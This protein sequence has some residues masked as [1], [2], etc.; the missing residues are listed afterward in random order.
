MHWL[1]ARS[2]ASEML[3]LKGT[4]NAAVLDVARA[5]KGGL[6]RACMPSIC[7]CIPLD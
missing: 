2:Q 7:R 1:D 4:T 3:S 5:V 6:Q